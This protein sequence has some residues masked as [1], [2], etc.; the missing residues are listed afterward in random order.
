MREGGELEEARES[1]RKDREWENDQLKA[2]N[3]GKGKAVMGSKLRTTGKVE[4]AVKGWGF[5]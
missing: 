5:R 1:W 4:S 2:G 3:S